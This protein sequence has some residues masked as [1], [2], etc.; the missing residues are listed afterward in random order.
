M[1]YYS[2][3]LLDRSDKENIKSLLEHCLI[4]IALANESDN[5]QYKEFA[6]KK[7]FELSRYYTERFYPRVK[8]YVADMSYTEYSE[9]VLH[10]VDY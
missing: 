7:H 6:N 9:A 4:D 2:K 8:G 5:Q 1:E 3:T 10:R